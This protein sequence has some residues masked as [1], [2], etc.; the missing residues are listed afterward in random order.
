MKPEPLTSTFRL[1]NVIKPR[2][3]WTVKATAA[4]VGDLKKRLRWENDVKINE[5]IKEDNAKVDCVNE[6]EVG[7]YVVVFSKET[8]V[9]G[10][11]I[12]CLRNGKSTIFLMGAST[13]PRRW[14][15]PDRTL[16]PSI[17]KHDVR[18]R[19]DSPALTMS[20]GNDIVISFERV[21]LTQL[22]YQL[23]LT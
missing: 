5:E 22:I 7:E 3:L 6:L 21:W 16:I 8:E 12:K 20:H 15:W 1:T 23:T 11:I 9:P 14:K 19:L 18:R 13:R 17:F 10:R 2:R 4:R